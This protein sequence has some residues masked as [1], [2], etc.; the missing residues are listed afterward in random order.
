[1]ITDVMTTGSDWSSEAFAPYRAERA[2]RMRRL[3]FASAGSYLLNGFGP[4]AIAKRRRLREMF[5]IDPFASPV[6]TAL[7]GAWVLP[8]EMYSDEAWQALVAA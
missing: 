6:A 3:R 4:E 1:M 8:E 2:E 5:A 7:V